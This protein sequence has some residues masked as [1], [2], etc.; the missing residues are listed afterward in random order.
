M[1]WGSTTLAFYGLGAAALATS[2]AKVRR[3]LQ[4]SR[5]KHWSL[6]GHARLARRVAALIPSYHYDDARFFR[7]DDAPDEVAARRRAGFE[8]LAEVYRARF[9]E[10]ARRTAEMSDSVSDLQFTDA[11]R[12]PF[13]YSPFVRRHLRAGAFMQSSAGVK[14]TDLDGNEF[15]DLTAAYGVNIFAYDFYKETIER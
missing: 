1:N 9:A 8:R 7:S 5:S 10:T 11:Y 2:L 14:L 13:Q 6:T 4:L 3:R 15:Y 12:V